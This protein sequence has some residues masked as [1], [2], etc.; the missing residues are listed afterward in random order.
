[1]SG[2][3]RAGVIDSE[4]MFTV[5]SWSELRTRIGSFV[6]RSRSDSATAPVTRAR[7]RFEETTTEGGAPGERLR[8]S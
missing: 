8:R 2:A 4:S 7:R 3:V 6:R 5:I 1:M